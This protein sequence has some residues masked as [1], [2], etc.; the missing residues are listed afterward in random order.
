MYICWITID[1]NSIPFVLLSIFGQ[2]HIVT[3][4]I[5]YPGS[6][7]GVDI[8]SVL[9]SKMN[10]LKGERNKGKTQWYPQPI[11]LHCLF[12]MNTLICFPFTSS[13]QLRPRSH[14]PRPKLGTAWQPVVTRNMQTQPVCKWLMPGDVQLVAKMVLH[15]NPHCYCF[16]C[17]QNGTLAWSLRE[18]S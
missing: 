11:P 3:V 2:E 10:R 13:T 7:T 16:V 6:I 18:R 12:S 5:M 17:Q 14:R 9:K 4:S 15:Q 1:R 8:N